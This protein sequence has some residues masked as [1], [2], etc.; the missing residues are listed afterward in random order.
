VISEK[1]GL[2]SPPGEQV[3]L[4]SPWPLLLTICGV[5]AAW[6]LLA[7]TPLESLE[8]RWFGQVLRWRYDKGAAPAV[9][10]SIVHV[11]VTRADLE[12]L[13]TLEMEYRSAATI[14]R[15]ATELGA[16]VVAFDVVFARG[17]AAMAA[18]ILEEAERAQS[19]NRSVIFAEALLP[20]VSDGKVERVR[21]FPFR[22]RV[23]PAGL[24][25]VHA[26]DDG[27]LRRYRYVHPANSSVVSHRSPSP[28]ILAGVTSIGIPASLRH[29]RMSCS[30]RKSRATSRASSHGS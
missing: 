16:R 4:R 28:L 12:K 30:G 18:P 1:P 20:S 5:A 2:S 11:D 26:D 6:V 17:D 13:P 27:V 10:P 23:Q 14:I 7:G 25:N 15:Q 8:M 19:E 24:I 29:G 3:W 9:D 22:E 21:S